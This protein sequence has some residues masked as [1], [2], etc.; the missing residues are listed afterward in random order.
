MNI[1][2]G[3]IVRAN[4]GRDKNGFFIV[5]D[6]DSQYAYIGASKKEKADSY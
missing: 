6:I 4:A 1:V 2:K 3:S 5:L